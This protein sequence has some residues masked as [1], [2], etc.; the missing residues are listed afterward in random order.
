MTKYAIY[1]P[2]SLRER[3]GVRDAINTLRLLAGGMSEHTITGSWVG[4][5]GLVT[6]SIQVV[7]YLFE[8]DVP[9]KTTAFDANLNRLV[10][11]L[12]ELGEES[13]LIEESQVTARFE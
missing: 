7:S 5:S 10:A 3:Y 4:Q 13:V 2:T 12:H 6:E 1:V 9:A 11:E 8:R